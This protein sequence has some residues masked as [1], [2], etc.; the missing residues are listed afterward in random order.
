LRGVV[1]RRDVLKVFA[2]TDQDIQREITED[3]VRD[4]FWI[5]PTAIAITVEDGI[6]HLHGHLEN[7]GQADLMC[8]MIRRTDG[9]V[10]VVNEIDFENGPRSKPRRI[11]PLGIFQHPTQ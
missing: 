1:S 3:V 6:V 2:R 8:G 4:M 5:D 9:V 10:A 11:S 7:W